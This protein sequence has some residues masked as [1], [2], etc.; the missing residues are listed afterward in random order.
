MFKKKYFFFCFSLKSFPKVE[1]FAGNHT[2]LVVKISTPRSTD[3]SN[4]IDK[5]IRHPTLLLPDI[6]KFGKRK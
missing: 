3:K 6:I 4:N 1:I 2:G 5:N